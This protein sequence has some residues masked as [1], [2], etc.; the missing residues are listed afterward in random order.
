M[1]SPQGQDWLGSIFLVSSFGHAKKERENRKNAS[2]LS[3]QFPDEL[4]K[5]PERD[6][7][8]PFFY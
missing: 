2:A 7:P 3:L 8:R 5:G 6:S 1:G 4:K